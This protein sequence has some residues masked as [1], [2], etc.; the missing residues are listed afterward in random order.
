[1]CCLVY[2]GELPQNIAFLFFS[3]QT[4]V[5][6]LREEIWWLAAVY[7]QES[8]HKAWCVV[9]WVEGTI[10]TSLAVVSPDSLCAKVVVLEGLQPCF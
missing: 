7:K 3:E 8:P 10:R 1:M 9:A 6:V 2:V 5:L 4:D